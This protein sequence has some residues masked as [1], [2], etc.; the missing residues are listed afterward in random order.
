[1]HSDFYTKLTDER[2]PRFMRQDLALFGDNAY[3]QMKFMIVPYKG[4]WAGPKDDFNYFHSQGRSQQFV[5]QL[6]NG[7]NR[8]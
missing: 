7:S 4:A 8:N 2:N 1:V 6:G 5:F 3:V